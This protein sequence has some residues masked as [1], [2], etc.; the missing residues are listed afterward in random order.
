MLILKNTAKLPPIQKGVL[1][2][3]PIQS[4]WEG[5]NLRPLAALK[6]RMS[7]QRVMASITSI[8]STAFAHELHTKRE[9]RL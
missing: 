2:S 9:G 3:N 8:V 5:L 4:G 7:P 6:E 1:S